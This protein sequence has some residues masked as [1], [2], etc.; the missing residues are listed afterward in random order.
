MSDVF[1]IGSLF[2]SIIGAGEA[3]AQRDQAMQILNNAVNQY[4]Q[5]GMPPDES[6]PLVLQQFKQQG[7][8]TPELEQ[9]IRQDPSILTNYQP[10][11]QY[12]NAQQSALQSMLQRGQGGLTASDRANYNQILQQNEQEGNSKRQALLQNYASRGL[13]G[14]G[15]ELAAQLGAQQQDSQNLYNSGLQV[16]G[17]AN[18]NALQAMTQAGQLGTQLSNQDFQTAKAK[19]DAQD[20]INRFNTQNALGVQN[21]NVGAQNSAQQANLQNAQRVSDANALM[22][23][24][25]AQRQA[26]AKQAYW[27]SLFGLAGAK[28]NALNGQATQV[29]A[30]AAATG[31]SYTNIAG[32]IGRA[33]QAFDPVFKSSSSAKSNDNDDDES[34]D[35]SKGVGSASG[36]AAGGAF[37]TGDY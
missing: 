6:V 30:N 11:Q 26:Q 9:Q 16:A 5:M 10:N 34:A 4:S 21:Y 3:S 27:N 37:G 15:A 12:K 13:A 18:Q 22:S 35:F 1:G 25:E 36:A 2:T 28:A 20:A 19:S 31:Q 33:G 24:Q 14:G 32:G 29:N 8:L 7:V 17:Q 23:N